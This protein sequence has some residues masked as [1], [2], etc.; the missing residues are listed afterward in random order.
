MKKK[1]KNT[2]K[3]K[4]KLCQL[5][6]LLGQ[7]ILLSFQYTICVVASTMRLK[8]EKNKKKPFVWLF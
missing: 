4:R 8:K 2:N 1:K 5:A 3:R 7:H 6:S